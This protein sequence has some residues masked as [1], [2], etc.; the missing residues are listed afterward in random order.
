M[1][2]QPCRWLVLGCFVI[3]V[4]SAC[5][6][7]NSSPPVDNSQI[8]AD[9]MSF[10]QTFTA[11]NDG[12]S[13][14][15]VLL[16]P[17][18]T[19]AQG[20][21]I[22]HLRTSPKSSQDIASA[23]L[24]TSEI[25]RQAYYKFDFPI[26]SG[27]ARKDY[28]LQVQVEGG[29]QVKIFTSPGESY[30]D[31]ALYQDLTPQDAQLA[32]TLSYNRQAYL[33]GVISIIAS[34]IPVILFGVI[35]FILPGWGLFSLLWRNWD[36]E[37][38]AVKLG[39]A[40]GLSLAIYPLFMLWTN[41]A[42]LYLGVLYAAIPPLFGVLALLWKYRKYITRLPERVRQSALFN[43]QKFTL[44][45]DV[46][47]ADGAFIL[48]LGL[49]IASR[50]WI[51]RSLDVPLFGD[52]YQHT[53]ISQLIIDHGGLFNSWQPYADLVT[54]TYHF[55]FHSTVAVYHWISGSSVENSMLWG[56][57]LINI[58]AILGLYPLAYKTTKNRWAGVV[59]MLIGGLLSSMPNYYVNWGRYTQLAGQAILPMVIWV[60]WSIFDRPHA[61]STQRTF[62]KK[63]VSWRYLALDLGSLAVVWIALSGLALTH[64][65]ILILAVL[66]FPAIGLLLLIGKAFTGWFG[67]TIWM[68]LGGGVLFLPWF[69][70][71]FGGKIMNMFMAGVTSLPSV[72]VTSTQVISNIKDL[73]V[74]LPTLIW[75]LLI[76]GVA[77]GLLLRHKDLIVFTIWWA[78]II[79]VTNPNWIGLPGNGVITNFAI[80]IAFY[81]PASVVIGFTV[82]W[83]VKKI[84]ELS[85]KILPAISSNISTNTVNALAL[86][87]VI[88][89]GIWGLPNRLKDIDLS[90]YT[91]V[92][93]PDLR[94]MT[95][96]RENLPADANFLVNSFFAFD[97]SVVV[98]SDGGWWIP[99]L[100][101]R[102][103]TLPPLTYGFE[104]G[105]G[106]ATI[107][108]ANT[109]VREVQE[110]GIANPAIIS[111][112]VQNSI[113]YI[114][115]GQRQGTINYNGPQV[116]DPIAMVKEPVFK[117]VYHQDRVWIFEVSP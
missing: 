63:L 25:S 18:D 38:W 107:D 108:S 30:L 37:N 19:S 91:L 48:M 24:P 112:L 12:L 36:K 105:I 57:Q 102:K 56:G 96:I 113:R 39:L 111:I 93:R 52:S 51:I 6:T 89:L 78:L 116:L 117:V 53:M 74:Y 27:S 114:Y 34:W 17:V 101:D 87:V 70:H 54:F 104:M 64:Y 26:Q 84:P 72:A 32:F 45:L 28:Y 10:G 69:I 106:T 41:L 50:F 100:A 85:K 95:W 21:L 40:G 115:I 31:G 43:R 97:N 66:F 14:I 68:G 75:L 15:S 88:A 61:G 2:R 35:L 33:L 23:V 4:L 62:I 11:Q 46:F 13:G 20:N 81:F 98:G 3:F 49:V 76:F 94:A 47:L 83:F 22:F 67:K 1:K 42:G 110:K 80:Q 8:V 58:L 59:A 86:V 103:T 92:T 79:L 9:G 65:R 90:S 77:L 7:S 73:T 109:L 60:A 5:S 55:G 99:L 29:G 44:T 16:G 82:S 71:V